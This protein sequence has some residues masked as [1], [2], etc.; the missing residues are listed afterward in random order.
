MGRGI[1]LYG[2][3]WGICIFLNV[4][5]GKPID[6]FV[7]DDSAPMREAIRDVLSLYGDIH[8]S[9][10]AA[11]VASA[12]GALKNVTGTTV[13]VDISLGGRD[14]GLDLIGELAKFRG[15]R[16]IAISAHAGEEFA[17]RCLKA[18]A[19]RFVAKDEILGELAD[20]IRAVS[21]PA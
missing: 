6:V 21:G 15:L 4:Q 19:D 5:K 20:A 3:R 2:L 11:S 14:D 13:L 16:L 10:E 9:G 12:L 8:V 18:G 7:V 17:D 1:P